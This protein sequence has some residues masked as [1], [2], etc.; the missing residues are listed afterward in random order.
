MQPA[1]IRS[2]LTETSSVVVL[3]HADLPAAND[4]GATASP[5]NS[6]WLK[7]LPT[8]SPALAFS[9][10]FAAAGVLVALETVMTIHG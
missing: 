5:R 8:M 1:S 6:S 7:R 4:N 9:F 2:P 10:G 3:C